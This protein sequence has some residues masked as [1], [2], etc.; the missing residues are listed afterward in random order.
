MT[1]EAEKSPS[2]DSSSDPSSDT[3]L[4]R[5]LVEEIKAARATALEIV[6][7]R[8]AD[9]TREDIWEEIIML[10]TM[11]GAASAECSWNGGSRF[12]LVAQACKA[13]ERLRDNA[14]EEREATAAD[15]L[16]AI[17]DVGRRW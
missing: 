16:Q 13:M 17:R 1:T 7:S 4:S 14:P 11:C 5:R 9:F 6:A 15:L 2:P 8:E 12:A 10:V 3:F